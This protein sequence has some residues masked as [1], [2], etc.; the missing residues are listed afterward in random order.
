MRCEHTDEDKGVITVS[1][2]KDGGIMLM[3]ADNGTGI[4]PEHVPHLF[5]RF[6]RAE[7]SRS[8]QSGGAGLG[9]AITKTI[10]DSHNGTIEVKSEQEKAPCSSSGRRDKP[11]SRKKYHNLCINSKFSKNNLSFSNIGDNI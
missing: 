1:L 4:A 9:L 11:G 3:I 7:T 5:D 6:Y 2:Q 8:R 10:I